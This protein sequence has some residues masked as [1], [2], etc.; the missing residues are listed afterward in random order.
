MSKVAIIGGSGLLGQYLVDEAL[1]R[2]HEVISTYKG[3]KPSPGGKA[4]S[5]D[6]TDQNAVDSFFSLEMPDRVLLP[7]AM[8]NVD[9]CERRP[10]AAFSVNV[11]GTMNVAQACKSSGTSLLYVSTDYV[12]NGFKGSKYYEFENPDPLSIYSKTK[13]EGERLV[14]DSSKHNAVCRVAVLYGW[15]RLTDKDNFVSWVIRSVRAGNEVK[16]FK[17]QFVTA[18]YAPHCAKVLMEVSERGLKGLFHTSGPD[19]LSRY[20]MG[21]VIADVFGLDTDLMKPHML[22]DANLLAKRARNTCLNVENIEAQLDMSMMPFRAGLED[23]RL[24]ELDSGNVT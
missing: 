3:G 7:A 19:C 15:N 8:T 18:T 12:F 1:S 6:M 16:L 24:T 9:E 4:V 23:M 20:Q 10:Q 14:M 17:D 5:L 13:L 21:M 22:E 2:G 11:E